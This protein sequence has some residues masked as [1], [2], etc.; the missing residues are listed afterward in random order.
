[1]NLVFMLML[2]FLARKINLVLQ[3]LM[4]SSFIKDQLFIICNASNYKRNRVKISKIVK[5]DIA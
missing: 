2:I 5:M 1:M 4:V 3:T